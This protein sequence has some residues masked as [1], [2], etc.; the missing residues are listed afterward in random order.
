MASNRILKVLT[1]VIYTV[2]GVTWVLPSTVNAAITVP[3]PM[4]VI[5]LEAAPGTLISG[6]V[7]PKYPVS[8]VSPKPVM[9]KSIQ[10]SVYRCS[11]GPV[12]R[13]SMPLRITPWTL[14]FPALI[15][16]CLVVCSHGRT[17]KIGLGVG[18]GVGVG[19][20]PG[21]GVG[22]GAGVGVGVG[23]TPGVGVGAGVAGAP[24][25]VI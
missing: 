21:V 3:S 22:V 24:L 2:K 8:L 6:P 14:T 16:L 19:V 25:V 11:A 1:P 12:T 13:V 23:V 18:N 5:C 4:M 15:M 17:V 20:E 10:E 9:S 7:R